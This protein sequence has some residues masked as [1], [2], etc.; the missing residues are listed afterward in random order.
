MRQEGAQLAHEE[1]VPLRSKTSKFIS[2]AKPK[3]ISGQRRTPSSYDAA[4]LN[5]T[6]CI[7]Y[8]FDSVDSFKSAC[9]F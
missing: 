6:Y 3:T 9:R 8:R 2:K 4:G 5:P 1:I 7:V